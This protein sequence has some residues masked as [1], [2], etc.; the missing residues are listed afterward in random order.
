MAVTFQGN[1]K[2]QCFIAAVISP[3]IDLVLDNS[4]LGRITTYY[5]DFE[6]D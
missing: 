4:V 2:F 6:Y 1:L 3:A 5:F